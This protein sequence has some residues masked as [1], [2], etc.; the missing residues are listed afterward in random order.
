MKNLIIILLLFLTAC[1][2]KQT[3]QVSPEKEQQNQAIEWTSKDS[4]LLAEQII[5]QIEVKGL[6]EEANVS[7]A[8]II[9]Y[10]P[11]K[12]D[13]TELENYLKKYS[14]K[15]KI[16]FE[17]Y[18]SKISVKI[19]AKEIAALITFEVNILDSKGK[20]VSYFTKKIMKFYR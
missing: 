5:R 20:A 8:P 17:T 15:T 19:E 3:L 13:F 12:I 2:T 1:T 18:Q 7:F 11:I 4:K 9:N 16:E 10:S 14:P 6:F